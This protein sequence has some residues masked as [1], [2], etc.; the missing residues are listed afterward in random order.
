MAEEEAVEEE[1]GEATEEV[2]EEET[3]EI[4]LIDYSL[5]QIRISLARELLPAC[6][7]VVDVVVEGPKLLHK[8]M[9]KVIEYA[10]F[11]YR[12]IAQINHVIFHTINP[13]SS[14][15]DKPKVKEVVVVR[16]HVIMVINAIEQTADLPIQ[17]M[18]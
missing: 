13:L 5:I 3:V 12:D 8:P 10:D 16:G 1:V 17:E 9:P 6:H 11:S 18:V 15:Q 14:N 7:Q 4:S 2:E